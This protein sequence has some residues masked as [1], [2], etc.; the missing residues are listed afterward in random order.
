MFAAEVMPEFHAARRDGSRRSA[1]AAA[2]RRCGAR[3]KDWM[4]PLEDDEIPIVRASVAKAQ[5]P[6]EESL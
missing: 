2:V 3:R 5:V 4:R 6:D 1:R